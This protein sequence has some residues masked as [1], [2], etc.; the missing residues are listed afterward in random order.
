MTECARE[1]FEDNT[2]YV[3]SLFGPRLDDALKP[4][5]GDGM[6]PI[7]KLSLVSRIQSRVIRCVRLLYDL[8]SLTLSFPLLPSPTHPHVHLESHVGA[9][10]DLM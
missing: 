9:Q 10:M 5:H 1:R 2:R 7:R 4:C 8:N 3:I 6:I